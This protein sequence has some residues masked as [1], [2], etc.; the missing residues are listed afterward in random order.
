[1]VFR[2]LELFWE[3]RQANFGISKVAQSVWIN[4]SRLDNLRNEITESIPLL[5]DD[6]KGTERIRRQF[7]VIN[8]RLR[9]ESFLSEIDHCW[10]QKA[11]IRSSR[12][13]RFVFQLLVDHGLESIGGKTFAKHNCGVVPL[14]SDIAIAEWP[15][16]QHDDVPYRIVSDDDP[17]PYPYQTTPPS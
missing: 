10:A 15:P 11:R 4:S 1:M 12:A 6:V 5:C 14:D 2:L 7:Q 8:S 3:A 13:E 9:T 16:H 17:F